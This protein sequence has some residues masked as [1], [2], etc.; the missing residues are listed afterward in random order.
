MAARRRPL[1]D[2]IIITD[3]DALEC[4]ANTSLDS[5]SALPEG[6]TPFAGPATLSWSARVAGA[7]RVGFRIN[8]RS[9]GRSGSMEVTPTVATT[10]T[11]SAHVRRASRVLGRVTVSMDT[12]ACSTSEL[13]ESILRG[14]VEQVVEAFGA[15]DDRAYDAALTG[16]DIT[17]SGIRMSI[18]AKVEVDNFFDPT[19]YV[20]LVVRP[21]VVEGAV[22]ARYASFSVDIDWPWYI[23]TLSAG[24]TKIV[25]E[26]KEDGVEAGLKRDILARIQARIDQ[27]VGLL[28][29]D[30]LVHAVSLSQD[31]IA[32]TA[33][34]TG[35]DVPDIRLPLFERQQL[36]VRG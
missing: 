5:F 31:A 8:G 10:Y 15:E 26:F 19:L 1:D 23:T 33:C 29:D 22:E 35:D 9:V 16:F 6:L 3:D 20:D 30:K 4:L 18:R 13:P 24:I 11:L 12:D 17:P 27:I 25:E 2:D 36:R 21:V 34:P 14:Q 32:V 28:G 7:C